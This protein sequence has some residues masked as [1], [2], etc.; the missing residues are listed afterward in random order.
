[1]E[2]AEHFHVS[3]WLI[4]TTLVNRKKVSREFL[5]PQT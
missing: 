4:R 2:A 1:M 3:E 5:P